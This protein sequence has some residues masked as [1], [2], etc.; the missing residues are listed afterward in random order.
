M[1]GAIALIL[2]AA[3]V[4]YAK[5]ITIRGRL[6]QTAEP[7]GWIIAAGNTKYLILN[8]RTFQ[9]ESWFKETADVEAVGETKDVMTT[10]MEGT[11]FEA[12]TLHPA[13]QPSISP[14]SDVRYALAGRCLAQVNSTGKVWAYR[15]GNDLAV[16]NL[17]P[18]RKDW[19]FLF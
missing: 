11:P 1:T 16:P 2:G 4:L 10:Y 7:G 17:I 19:S 8:A 15:S 14:A 12:R 3:S 9:K 5:E 18:T 6:Q 13:D